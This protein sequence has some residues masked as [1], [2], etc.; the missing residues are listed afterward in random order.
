LQAPYND[1][2][3]KVAAFFDM[4]DE[5]RQRAAGKSV[6]DIIELVLGRTGYRDFIKD[7]SLEG[8]AR[9]E[10]ILEF[11]GAAQ[12]LSS[13][14]DFLENVALVQDTEQTDRKDGPEG[15]LTLMTIH[16]AKGLEFPVVFIAGM[17]E[18]IFPHSRALT[19]K[20]EMEEERRLAYVGMTRAKERLYLLHAFERRLYG[21]LQSNASSR[22]IDEIPEELR[23]KI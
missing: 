14:D 3:P 12:G 8:E 10:N 21:L 23:Q 2:A 17:E 5:I 4:M 19:E 9:W 22:F 1:L 13:L 15:A 6:D 7:G 11:M 18:G 20:K 16:A